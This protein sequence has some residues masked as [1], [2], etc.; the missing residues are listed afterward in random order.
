[1]ICFQRYRDDNFKERRCVYVGHNMQ[2]TGKE[3]K[4]ETKERKNS[5][6][7]KNQSIKDKDFTFLR[8]ERQ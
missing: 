7:E 8:D 1:M 5:I 3:D 6:H 4:K 2:Y